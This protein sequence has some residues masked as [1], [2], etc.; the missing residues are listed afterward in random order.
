MIYV[1][2][3]KAYLPLSSSLSLE[4]SL[5]SSWIAPPDGLLPGIGCPGITKFGL[6]TG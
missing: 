6:F 4:L 2:I 3:F 5:D 1:I